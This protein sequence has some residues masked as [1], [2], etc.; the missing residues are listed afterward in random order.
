MKRLLSVFVLL[1]ASVSFAWAQTVKAGDEAPLFSFLNSDGERVSLS[2]FRG[3]YVYIDLWASWCGPCRQQ[4]PYLMELEEKMK[5]RNIV[6]ISISIDDDVAAWRKAMKEDDL[7]GIQL[8]TYTEK[9]IPD[10]PDVMDLGNGKRT[11]AGHELLMAYNAKTIP[12]FILIDP[13]GKVVNPQFTRPS[14]PETEA[15]LRALKGI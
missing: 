5:D 3:K 8:H 7:K 2:D 9:D 15:A 1:L 12:H 10:N 11:V 13:E 6:F 14:L 4:G